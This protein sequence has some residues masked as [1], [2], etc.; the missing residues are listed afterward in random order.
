MGTDSLSKLSEV[1]NRLDLMVEGRSL[2]SVNY[3]V[4]KG[5]SKGYRLKY[6]KAIAVQ[7]NIMTKGTVFD[8]HEHLGR[9]WIIVY[10]GRIQFTQNG[11]SVILNEGEGLVFEPAVEHEALALKD[12]KLIGITIPPDEGYP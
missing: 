7:D 5:S 6:T 12:T 8:V 10:E 3:A 2:I 4:S 11:D 1:N 9:E